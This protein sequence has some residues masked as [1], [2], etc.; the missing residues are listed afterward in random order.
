MKDIGIIMQS[1]SVLGILAN[2]KSVTR[3]LAKG[4][5][6]YAP[7]DRNPYPRLWVR[8]AWGYRGGSHTVGNDYHDVRIEYRADRVTAHFRLDKTERWP[9]GHGLPEQKCK[10]APLPGDDADGFDIR[11]RHG[12][13]LS[14][15]W[16]AWRSPMYMPR[17]AARISLEVVSVREERLLD[18][19][20]EDAR[21]E[22]MP[23]WSE[24]F[25]AFGHGQ[26]LTTGE[27]AIDRPYRSSYAVAWDEINPGET[28]KSNPVVWR[29]EFKR[30]DS[31]QIIEARPSK[32]GWN[33]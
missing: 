29:I 24:R 16:A 30:A 21:L 18:I 32:L 15:Y 22:G 23:H 13:E 5:C 20:D 19:T 2:R 9:E 17:W 27:V 26:R 28:W 3:R 6:R 8:E 1:P 10:C 12:D 4:P 31:F 7:S 33:A 14:A 11:C 25:S